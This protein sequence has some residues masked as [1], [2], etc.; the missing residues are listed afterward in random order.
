MSARGDWIQTA[1]GRQFWP[2]DPRPHEVYIDDIA[3]ALSLLCRFGGHC[4]RFYSVAEHCVLLSR[5]APAP[6]KLWALLHDASEAYLVDVPRPLKPFLGGYNE[7]EDKI[8]R[9]IAFRF[10]LHLGMPDQVK[11]LDRAILMDE[12][13]QNMAEAPIAWSTDCEPLGI[14]LQFWSPERARAEFLAAFESLGG[15]A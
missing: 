4:L 15:R 8:M 7:A 1:T 5:I 11:R 10:H 14:D 6:Y 3:H 9:A 2:M 13:L 12:R